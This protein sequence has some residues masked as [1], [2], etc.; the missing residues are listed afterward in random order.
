MNLSTI[1]HSLSGNI[2]CNLL[3]VPASGYARLDPWIAWSSVSS[4]ARADKTSMVRT[5]RWSCFHADQNSTQDSLI[6]HSLSLF[7]KKSFFENHWHLMRPSREGPDHAI[8]HNFSRNHA[9]LCRHHAITPLFPQS[10]HHTHFFTITPSRPKIRP[11][12]VLCIKMMKIYLLKNYLSKT[13]LLVFTIEI[14]RNL[15]N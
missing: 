14:C 2:F 8:T 1:Y 7:S 3:P 13:I 11:I 9:R 10:R 5:D 6:H 4:R 15:Q 12:C